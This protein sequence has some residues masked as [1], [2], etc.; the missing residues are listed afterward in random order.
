MV[1]LATVVAMIAICLPV[2]L[3]TVDKRVWFADHCDHA[4]T[5]KPM[6]L[7]NVHTTVNAKFEWNAVLGPDYCARYHSYA[8]T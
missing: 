7:T 3:P 2:L 4:S 1:S 6:Y 5:D 8:T